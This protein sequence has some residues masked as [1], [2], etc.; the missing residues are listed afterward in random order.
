MISKI[1]L[2]EKTLE[3]TEKPLGDPTKPLNGFTRK[4]FT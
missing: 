1:Q 4:Y 3:E 2:Q